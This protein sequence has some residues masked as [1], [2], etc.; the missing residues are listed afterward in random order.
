MKQT[1]SKTVR[2]ENIKFHP[3]HVKYNRSR[4][5]DQMI[6]SIAVT[7]NKPIYNVV[8]VPDPIKDD[9]Y[10]LILGG[11]RFQAQVQTGSE[12]I[13]V[14]VIDM[15]DEKEIEQYIIEGNTQKV[16]DGFERLIVFQYY[17]KQFPQQKGV[18]GNR[19]E[20]IGRLVNMGTDKVKD[21]V[22]LI[23]F[24]KGQGD[25]ILEK[26]FGEELTV[27]DAQL[28]QRSVEQTPE[29]FNS[30]ESFEKICDPKF[31]FKRLKTG[32]SFFGIDNHSEFDVLKQFLLKDITYQEL[33]DRAEQV[34]GSRSEVNSHN[35]SKSNVPILSSDYRSK[36]A[37]II[38]GD[39][40]LV[41]GELPKG[42]L[43]DGIIGSPFYGGRR[44]YGDGKVKERY[45]KMTGIESA[46]EIAETYELYKDV[47]SPTGS[48]YVIIDDY[49]TEKGDWECLLEF[50]VIEMVKR[51]FH[52]IGRYMW[53]KNNPIPNSHKSKK[54]VNSFEVIY[55]FVLDPK[56]YYTNP[57]LLLEIDLPDGHEFIV[58][59]GCTNPTKTSTTR[60][61]KYVQNQLKKIRNVLDEKT[62]NDIIKSN[63]NKPQ[64]FYRQVSEKK[65][66]AGAPVE[67]T[68]ALIL[69]CSSNE[70]PDS[71][72][73]D[74]WNG[75]GGTCESALLL[76]R[77]Y[78]GIEIDQNYCNQSNKRINGVEVMM[79]EYRNEIIS[80]PKLLA[81]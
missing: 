81:A 29:H 45:E 73:L 76:G 28:I 47:L 27:K 51:G 18:K 14:M 57:N 5:C 24:F 41:L 37:Q 46:I 64:D 20:K 38:K 17:E 12:E 32:L 31:D 53:Q 8:V 61:G 79:D 55:R 49:M 13:E 74:V 52:L 23:N 43:Y 65:H 68:A 77:K 4:N 22:M 67:L 80:T 39:N 44:I 3:L 21:L 56:N 63:V 70:N 33:L 30:P 60:G 15:T 75:V 7:G 72:I 40:K 6:E 10:L 19:Y 59:D 78:I 54:M 16:L 69:E 35:S 25:V 2:V 48:I 34:K 71:Y 36:N 9:K 11:I 66:T 50:F 26:V 58:K 62:C 1:T 42:I